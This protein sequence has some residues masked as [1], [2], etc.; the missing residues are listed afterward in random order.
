MSRQILRPVRVWTDAKGQPTRFV[1]RDV[2]YRGRILLVLHA[3]HASMRRDALLT[4]AQRHS[5]V[6]NYG[7]VYLSCAD[8]C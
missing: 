2:T 7:R 8:L 4:H 1:W 3:T 6:E 5:C